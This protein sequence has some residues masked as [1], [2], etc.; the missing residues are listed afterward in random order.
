MRY[1]ITKNMTEQKNAQMKKTC[2][3]HEC[4]FRAH[5]LSPT[6]HQAAFYLALQLAI[7]RQV[8]VSNVS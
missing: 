4:F 6:D 3:G 2:N 1:Y 8:S 5:S 7:S